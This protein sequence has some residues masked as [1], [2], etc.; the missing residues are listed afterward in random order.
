ML[1]VFLLFQLCLKDRDLVG[2]LAFEL[3]GVMRL[4]EERCA[5]VIVVLS[6]AFLKSKAN[7]FFTQFA[8]ALGVGKYKK[9]KKKYLNPQNLFLIKRKSS[10]FKFWNRI[11]LD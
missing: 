3:N 10:L 6:P 2:G 1:T 11:I 9:L 8:H 7:T 4:I 5:R